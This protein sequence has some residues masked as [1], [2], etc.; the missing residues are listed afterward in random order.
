MKQPKESRPVGNRVHRGLPADEERE[1]PNQT[2]GPEDYARPV[3]QILG[4][5]PDPAP[6]NLCRKAIEE[7]V[8]E[9]HVKTG[10]TAHKESG[11]Y[12]PPRGEVRTGNQDLAERSRDR[13]HRSQEQDPRMPLVGP[14]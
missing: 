14:Q 10:E 2:S 5:R 1:I 12:L 3:Q 6:G 7:M 11:G 13:G 9:D 8:K 4:C